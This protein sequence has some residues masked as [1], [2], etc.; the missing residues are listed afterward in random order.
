ML[1]TESTVGDVTDPVI[2]LT[3]EVPRLQR[4]VAPDHG[5][6]AATS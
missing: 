3:G 1:L 4:V 2:V 5:V 6:V